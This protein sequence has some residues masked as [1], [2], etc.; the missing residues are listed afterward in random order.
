MHLTGIQHNLAAEDDYQDDDDKYKDERRLCKSV[1]TTYA[2]FDN[3]QDS[4]LRCN[5]CNVCFHND[6]NGQIQ[7]IV[8]FLVC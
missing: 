6:S 4:Y 8:L 2:I 3:H 7:I 5:Q 1:F